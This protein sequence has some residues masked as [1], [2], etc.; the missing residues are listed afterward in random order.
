MNH[1]KKLN[2]HWLCTQNHIFDLFSVR[3]A[4]TKSYV[5]SEPNPRASQIWCQ[6][7]RETQKKKVIEHRG[8][9]IARYGVI[10]RNV[11]WGG[12]GPPPRLFGVK[13]L[14]ECLG[15]SVCDQTYHVLVFSHR[16]FLSLK[17]IK[18]YLIFIKGVVQ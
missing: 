1:M 11:E 13:T 8:E 16:L 14:I 17:S 15:E 5:T 3:R 18:S 9:S 10:A 12:L 2:L 6:N 4:C 7:V